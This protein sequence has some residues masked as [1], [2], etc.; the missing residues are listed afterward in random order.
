MG[1]GTELLHVDTWDYIAHMA[2]LLTVL[3]EGP[4]RDS[5]FW[6]L[7]QDALSNLETYAPDGVNLKL[8]Y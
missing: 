5:D 4:N 7:Q 2:N 3:L 1:P 8:E 6:F